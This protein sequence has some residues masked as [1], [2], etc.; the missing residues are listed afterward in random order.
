MGVGI[1]SV[2]PEAFEDIMRLPQGESYRLY[3]V[4]LDAIQA[5]LLL[6][7]GYEVLGAVPDYPRRVYLIGVKCD[8]IPDVPAGRRAPEV[9]PTYERDYETGHV[10]LLRVDVRNGDD[11]WNWHPTELPPQDD[12][13][14]RMT[15]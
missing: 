5:A 14:A 12:V 11:M 9:T 13:P 15:P 3:D 6:P 2:T 10:R 1:I 8:A 7:E 4:P